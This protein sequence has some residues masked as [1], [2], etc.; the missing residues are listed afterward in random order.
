MRICRVRRSRR[1]SS[2]PRARLQMNNAP[3]SSTQSR[4]AGCLQ[5]ERAGEVRTC[6]AITSS[7]VL[8]HHVF[9]PIGFDWGCRCPDRWVGLLSCVPLGTYAIGWVLHG[10]RS[11][12][13]P[14]EA[15]MQM[16]D[17][18]VCPVGEKSGARSPH[19]LLPGAP[20]RARDSPALASAVSC[21]SAHRF[22]PRPN[23]IACAYFGRSARRCVEGA[24]HARDHRQPS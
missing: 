3:P 1:R 4:Y 20:R 7:F 6:R 14:K 15:P 21:K 19:G 22:P 5:D 8:L 16:P 2:S 13:R 23:P 17:P 12:I 24:A 10:G 18:S 9:R 11:A